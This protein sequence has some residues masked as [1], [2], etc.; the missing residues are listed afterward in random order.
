MVK[1]T[2][3]NDSSSIYARNGVLL[4]PLKTDIS[5]DQIAVNVFH[6]MM[7]LGVKCSDISHVLINPKVGCAKIEVYK[8]DC[9]DY[10]VKVLKE[11]SSIMSLYDLRLLIEK[12]ALLEVIRI[13]HFANIQ[14]YQ[15]SKQRRE[16]SCK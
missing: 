13:S 1:M 15:V 2:V 11:I 6:L 16:W 7:A 9:E 10:I 3:M 8:R 5:A 12:P 14:N 4:A